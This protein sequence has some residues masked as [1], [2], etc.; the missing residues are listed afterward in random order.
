[1]KKLEEL[2][3]EK[4]EKTKITLHLFMQIVGKIRLA[5][6]PRKNHWWYITLYLCPKGIT[7]HAIP[8]NN[9]FDSFEITFNFIDHQLEIFTSKGESGIIALEDGL[10]VASFYQKLFSLL[11]GF[12]ISVNIIDKPFDV[13]N[14][15]IAF[16]KNTEYASYQPEYVERFWHIML[17]VDSVFKEFSGRFYGKTCPVHIY[18][19]HMDLAVTR[20]SGKKAPA[21]P[22]EARISD[23]DAYTHEVISFGFWAGDENV[24]AP[25][26]YTYTYPS[27]AGL[28]KEIIKPDSANWIDNNG[29]PMGVLMYDDLCKAVDAR[30]TLLEFLE[31][32]YLAGAKLAGWDVEELKVVQLGDL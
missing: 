29:S 20:F 25:A 9:G 3:L 13:P 5:L 14:V 19:H 12:G 24:R 10:S 8:Y 6:A 30:K 11:A 28:D 18:W 1:M 32:S 4:W 2:P 22:K 21:M 15:E 26:F 7:T 17:W 16:S 23:K 31:S 27:P